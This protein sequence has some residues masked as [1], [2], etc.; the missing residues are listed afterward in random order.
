[1]SFNR[2]RWNGLNWLMKTKD[3]PPEKI[4][5]GFEFN[6]LHT[7]IPNYKA[8]LEKSWWWVKDDTYALTLGPLDGYRIYKSFTYNRYIPPFRKKVYILK[9]SGNS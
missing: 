4:D 1:M 5:G 2:A 6:G 3:V 8:N 7:F 9:K